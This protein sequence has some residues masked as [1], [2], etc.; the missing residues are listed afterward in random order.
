[1]PVGNKEKHKNLSQDNQSPGPPEYEIEVITTW[2]W[3][4]VIKFNVWHAG[5]IVTSAAELTTIPSSDQTIKRK[6]IHN[7]WCFEENK[8][9][10]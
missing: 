8:R 9:H 10:I 2:L 1:M 7:I 4:S 5:I 6:I 3:Y